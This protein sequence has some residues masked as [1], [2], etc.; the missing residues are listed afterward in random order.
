MGVIADAETM[1]ELI[2]DCAELPEAVRH[3]AAAVPA[4]HAPGEWRVDDECLA[5][6]AGIDDYG[7]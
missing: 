2:S 3:P 5:Q 4:Q 7:V 1:A 6:V